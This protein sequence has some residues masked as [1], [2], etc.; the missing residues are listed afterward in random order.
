MGI[1]G[2]LL[3][4]QSIK[5]RR[6]MYTSS[7]TR[8]LDESYSNFRKS[9]GDMETED[10]EILLDAYT[11][12]GIPLFEAQINAIKDELEFR[13]TSLGKELL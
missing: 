5:E 9:L 3:I 6:N 13:N 12:M 8:V 11:I 1:I 10:L 2:R 4:L 7:K